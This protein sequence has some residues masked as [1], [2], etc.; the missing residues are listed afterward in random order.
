M[1]GNV[2]L[3][4]QSFYERNASE[5]AKLWAKSDPR[6]RQFARKLL[7]YLPPDPRRTI[8]VLDTGTGTARDVKMLR[9]R[10]YDAFGVD[11]S[12]ATIDLAV[13]NNP[14]L[15]GRLFVAD[16]KQLGI[17]LKGLSGSEKSARFG[18]FRGIWDNATFHHVPSA[19]A[20][21][22]IGQYVQVL[23]P[24]G[25]GICFLREKAGTEEGLIDT[26]E[27]SGEKGRFFKLWQ[28]DELRA[29]VEKHGFRVLESG[30]RADRR[31]IN[32]VW[33]FARLG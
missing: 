22:V 31:K 7:K 14:T 8:P 32:F 4:T 15:A 12:P 3:H 20:D 2:Y 25:P 10:G 29:L 11:F 17:W 24:V 26:G 18:G 21:L 1:T 23:S 5:Y 28:E 9:R 27:C 6:L 33:L 13:K 19:D 30:L 16:L